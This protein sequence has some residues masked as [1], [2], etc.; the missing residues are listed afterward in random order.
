M[1][2]TNKIFTFIGIALLTSCSHKNPD[3]DQ[4]NRATD[5]SAYDS[6]YSDKDS[7]FGRV[8]NMEICNDMLVLSHGEDEYHYSFIDTENGHLL[9]RWGKIG[10]GSE[11]FL[12]FGLRFV[13]NDSALVFMD[14]MKKQIVYVSLNDILQ[15]VRPVGKH[16]EAFPYTA[17]FRPFTF[18]MI[19]GYKFFT[20]AF[21]SS[22]WGGINPKGEIMPLHFDF[23][24]STD[25]LEGIYKGATF[26]GILK[27][28]EKQKKLVLM[29]LA[30][31]VFEIFQCEGDSVRKVYTSPF[32][33][34]PKLI[35]KGARYGIDSKNSIGGLKG[36]AVSDKLICFS[37]SPTVGDE[38]SASNIILCFDWNGNKVKKYILPFP[39]K[40]FCIDEHYIYGLR[41][42]EDYSV[43]YR[44][45]LES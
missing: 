1:N 24:F 33:H 38:S 26:Q 28:N 20:G 5:I 25:P 37:Y 27:A 3:I 39:I 30:S 21:K 7:I 12:D 22:S 35:K 19:G 14:S 8:F 11:E 18:S 29:T 45:R 2:L 40:K 10:Q 32:N 41:E 31:D 17:D 43:V 34:P 13:V 4:F 23:P 44:F 6:I 42:A 15:G 16:T 36:V 9:K